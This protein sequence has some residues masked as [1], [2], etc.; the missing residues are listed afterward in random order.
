MGE[1]KEVWDM[2]WDIYSK[3]EGTPWENAIP[4]ISSRS[5]TFLI[6]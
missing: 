6:S 1:I 3:A 4:I 5:C 2:L